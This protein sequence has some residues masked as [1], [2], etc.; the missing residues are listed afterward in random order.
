MSPQ[1]VKKVEPDL[2]KSLENLS[3]GKIDLKAVRPSSPLSAESVRSDRPLL[4]PSKLQNSWVAGGFW[5][6]SDNPFS[7]FS[8][9]SSQSSGYMSQTNDIN[10]FRTY[11]ENDKMSVY[12]SHTHD[13]P[14]KTASDQFSVFS[15]PAYHFKPINAPTFGS[16]HSRSP[17]LEHANRGTFYPVLN[18]EN[19]LELGSRSYGSPQTGVSKL[20]KN[21]SPKSNCSSFARPS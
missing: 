17:V 5:Y 14:L 12:S 3:L 10:T 9:S 1:S 8:R 11:P 13:N 4:S 19:M 18:S 20:F 7:H 15:E 6:N 2:H 16:V 21:L